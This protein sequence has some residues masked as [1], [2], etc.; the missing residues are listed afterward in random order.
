MQVQ[1][2]PGK[3]SLIRLVTTDF[4]FER[5]EGTCIVTDQNSAIGISGGREKSTGYEGE[6]G[7]TMPGVVV[8]LKVMVGD[9]KFAEEIE[10]KW[11]RIIVGSCAYIF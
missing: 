9:M 6:V 5:K 2:G 1:V 7:L 11:G 8:G 4:D 10:R 3:L